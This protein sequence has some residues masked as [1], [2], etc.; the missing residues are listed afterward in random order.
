[1]LGLIKGVL[2]TDCNCCH[3]NISEHVYSCIL[4]PVTTLL[5]SNL[6]VAGL[7]DTSSFCKQCEGIGIVSSIHSSILLS[8]F[9][10]ELD[11]VRQRLASEKN[12]GKYVPLKLF[13]R[14]QT[15][16]T[17]TDIV[18]GLWC[19]VQVEYKHLYRHMKHTAGWSEMTQQG[20]PV[21]LKT[22]EMKQGATI[23][24]K[25]G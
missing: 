5:G 3:G 4:L 23:H 25:K 18:S 8:P 20:R 6:S 11:D 19:E 13:R 10:L 7:P 21:Q 24:L 2:F 12:N 17:V 1:M 22:P 9:R 16:M 15:M 14:G